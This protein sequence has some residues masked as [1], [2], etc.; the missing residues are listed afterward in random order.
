[1]TTRERNVPHDKHRRM[2][3]GELDLHGERPVIRFTCHLR[4][5]PAKVW[6]ALT[7]P[8]HLSAWFPTTI[9]GDRA[10]GAPLVFRFVDMDLPPMEGIMVAYDPPRLM[11]FFWG[12][13]V[14]RFELQPTDGGCVLIVTDTVEDLGK[15]SRDG[16][17][18]HVCLE[19]LSHFVSGTAL[20]PGFDD[21]WRL[22][23]PHYV[24]AFGPEASTLGPPE[25]YEWA[26]D[27]RRARSV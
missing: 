13:D 22:I 27:E 24:A 7:E 4:H 21:R 10:A 17:G 14:M 6:C 23:H 12:E 18:W 1:M 16:A 9:D 2:P 3:F 11:E 8:E 25:E 26:E 19:R 15:A 20:P 5:A